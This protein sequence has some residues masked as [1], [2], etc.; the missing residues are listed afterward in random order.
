[1]T[2]A[3]FD[4]NEHPRG[5]GGMFV[6]KNASGY[7]L[8]P[9]N[10]AKFDWP[11]AIRWEK[12][13]GNLVKPGSI[14]LS[15]E[16]PWQDPED[17]GVAISWEARFGTLKQP[18]HPQ[19]DVHEQVK[20]ALRS[21]PEGGHNLSTVDGWRSYFAALQK[22]FDKQ[23]GKGVI[24]A[25]TIQKAVQSEDTLTFKGERFNM[26]T[27]MD[28][29]DYLTAVIADKL[30][31]S[32]PKAP[33]GKTK[34]RLRMGKEFSASESDAPAHGAVD[35]L[36]AEEW[37]PYQGDRGGV[38]E[39]QAGERDDAEAA[40]R[41]GG[42]AWEVEIRVRRPDG[43]IVSESVP[44]QPTRLQGLVVCGQ[45]EGD[46]VTLTH[47]ASGCALGPAFSPARI[48]DLVGELEKLDLDWSQ[49][50]AALMRSLTPAVRERIAELLA[51]ALSPENISEPETLLV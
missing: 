10:P 19:D 3:E 24:S 5:E 28:V 1:M 7:S 33:K 11:T 40:V 30:G 15:K 4:P 43:R 39:S 6:D 12:Q 42:L 49:G 47:Q 44:A 20:N 9:D 34:G 25:S 51:E 50:P 46:L 2:E 22:S 16:N 32:R 35:G 41:T 17:W 38:L 37:T 14:S 36:A 45:P 48:E 18:H 26:R 31:V 21:V 23:F 27:G 13:N 8:S 29:E